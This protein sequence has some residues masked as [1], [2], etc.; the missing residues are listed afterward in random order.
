MQTDPQSIAPRVRVMQ[1]I[2]V[3]LAMG[4]FTALAAMFSLRDANA[5]KPDPPV[6]TYLG[7]AFCASVVV[8]RLIVPRAIVSAVRAR[9]AEQQRTDSVEPLLGA[10]Q[11]RM[12]VAAALL[13]GGAFFMAVAYLLEGHA[14]ALGVGAALALAVAAHFPTVMGVA[15]WV[16]EQQ[17]RLR[18]ERLN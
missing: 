18:L 15:A 6:L 9:L 10:F 7:L 16:D 8:A 4:C 11:S 3:A 2:V 12:I 14:L 1:I 13:E 5:A 17:E